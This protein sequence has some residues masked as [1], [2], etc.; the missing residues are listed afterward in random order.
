MRA[1]SK[2]AFTLIELLIVVALFA[3]IAAFIVTAFKEYQQLQWYN[4]SVSEVRDSVNLARAQTMGGVND[5]V[6]GI[7]VGTS[8][9]ELFSGP[10][11]L[12]GSANNKIISFS[13]SV[14]ATSSFSDGSWYVSFDRIYGTPTATG[15]ISLIESDIGATTTFTILDSGLIQ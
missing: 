13:P 7:Y 1:V 10:V 4:L 8:T 14:Y 3:I 15:T 9:V 6:Y 11:P 5:T 2:K 12:V